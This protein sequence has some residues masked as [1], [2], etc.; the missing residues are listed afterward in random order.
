MK[1]TIL[2]LSALSFSFFYSCQKTEREETR[3]HIC[4][5]Q[6]VLMKK[7][8]PAEVPAGDPVNKQNLDAWVLE[9]QQKQG[10]FE[11]EMADLKTIWSA[12]QEKN[13]TL[14]IGYQPADVRNADDI[15]H[16]INIMEGDWKKTHDA[17]IQ[18][19]LDGLSKQEGKPVKWEDILVEDDPVLPI[20]TIRLQ[21]KTVLTSLYN[22]VNVRYLE[23]MDYWPSASHYRMA[24]TSGCSPSTTALNAADI[25]T[26]TPGCLLPWNFNNMN[27]PAAWAKSEGAGQRIGVIDAGISS[28]QSLLGADFNNGFSNTG[29]TVTVDYTYGSSAYTSCSHGTAM[30]GLAVGPRNTLNSTTGVAYKASLHFIRACSDVVLDESAEKTGVKNALVRMG[31]MA[32]INIISMSVGTPFG[33]SVL[34]DGCIYADGKGKMLFAAAGTSTSFTSW[35]GVIYPAYYAQCNAV[36]G[37]KESGA[38]CASCHDGSQ[39]DFTVLM[40]R[41]T[42]SN[43]NSVSL[44]PS[45]TLPSYIGGSSAATATAAGIAALVWSS[46]PG[47]TKAQVLTSLKSTAQFASSPSSSKGFGNLNAAAAVTMAQGL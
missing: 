29:R 46:K 22:L 6:D 24:S 44:S 12:L 41:T 23:P 5:Q 14:A 35:Y 18:L 3:L 32:N 8:A 11:W 13:H 9:T 28:S 42:N 7:S 33:S 1:Q 47:L 4:T 38:R 19:I 27:I 15:L 25:S 16:T 20:L 39:V 37:V 17:L 21:D 2:I 36:T 45:G 30:S 10:K 43:R 34:R 40:E 26:L 31:D